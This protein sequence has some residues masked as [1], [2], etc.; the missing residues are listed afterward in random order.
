MC[1]LEADLLEGTCF[2]LGGTCCAIDHNPALAIAIR[3]FFRVALKC[4]THD[5]NWVAV[6][7][8][9]CNW[10]WVVPQGL[11][12]WRI[13]KLSVHLISAGGVSFTT[14]EG[15]KKKKAAEQAAA[16]GLLLQLRR[17]CA[18]S[19]RSLRVQLLF[20]HSNEYV[21]EAWAIDAG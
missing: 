6:S 16:T 15:Y 4:K 1:V 3:P 19:L 12:Y 10:Q 18:I 20:I 17:R 2:A 5:F 7:C 9:R 21:I 11:L 13:G 8:P 14:T